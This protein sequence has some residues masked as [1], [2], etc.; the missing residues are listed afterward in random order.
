MPSAKTEATELSVAFGLLGYTDPTARPF[1]EVE[2][3]F[4]GTLIPEKHQAYIEEYTRPRNQPLYSRMLNVGA[5][6]RLRYPLFSNLTSL[7]WSG[8]ERQAATIATARDL[9]AVN[10]PI[11]V[12]AESRVV[13]N[14][15][16]YNI[17]ISTPQGSAQARGTRS[18]YLESALGQYQAYYGY[19][20]EITDN[21]SL[22]EDVGVFEQSRNKAPLRTALRAMVLNP[23]QKETEE[24]L[25]LEM[26][27][28]AASGAARIFNENLATSL[29]SRTRGSVLERIAKM[30]FRM[31]AVGYVLCG[32]D[33]R[34]DFAVLV[35]DLTSWLR[36][37]EFG[38]IQSSPDLTR[39][40]SVVDF[41]VIC[42]HKTRG[43]EYNAQFH[44]EVRWSHGRFSSVEGKLYKEFDWV[45]LPFF[46]TIF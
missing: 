46:E 27:H 5:N 14:P 18:W 30:F 25:Y 35:P 36:E 11:S 21:L 39:G 22:P 40:Q 10:V 26:C 44:A 38:E 33:G 8:P 7:R 34:S 4:E 17:F 41:S 23:Q 1:T 12:K 45:D 24:R 29:D 20:R 32:I 31:N 42:R 43:D 28:T 19:I 15:S 16:P 3:K 6:L 9:Q 2:E 13:G 37:W